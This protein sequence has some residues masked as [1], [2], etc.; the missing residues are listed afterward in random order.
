[1]T[2]T[3]PPPPTT[4]PTPAL[5]PAAMFAGIIG[6]KA[7]SLGF[8][9]YVNH[10]Q[11][12]PDRAIVVLDGKGKLDDR[13]LRGTHTANDLVEVQVRSFD[14]VEAG[15]FLPAVWRDVLQDITATSFGGKIVQCITKANTMG[16]MGQ[17][18]QTRRWRFVQSFFMTIT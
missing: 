4:T 1:M 10:M 7:Q 15:N 18:P 3:T 2:T 6:P 16:C 12:Q 14:H 17:E 5:T 8:R 9:V 11:D 13:S